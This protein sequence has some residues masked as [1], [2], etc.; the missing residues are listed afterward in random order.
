LGVRRS[1]CEAIL[2]GRVEPTPRAAHLVVTSET[3]RLE[4]RPDC[5]RD[6]VGQQIPLTQVDNRVGVVVST[7]DEDGLLEPL[8]KWQA[9]AT[10][11]EQDVGIAPGMKRF[12]RTR[13]GCSRPRRVDGCA[14]GRRLLLKVAFAQ[15]QKPKRRTCADKAE[16]V[17]RRLRRSAPLVSPGDPR[18]ILHARQARGPTRLGTGRAPV[19]LAKTLTN[20]VPSRD[21][22]LRGSIHSHGGSR[23][24]ADRP[25]PGPKFAT[26]WRPTSMRG[27]NAAHADRLK[28]T[29]RVVRC[30]KWKDI[31]GKS[32][33]AGVDR[34]SLGESFPSQR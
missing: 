5:I 1:P 11:P 26:A 22:M 14:R 16:G 9:S 3:R 18:G 25:A 8:E 24:N 31:G 33:P 2:P 34:W 29:I 27:A 15:V 21:S 13:S 32:N 28:R 6:S 23:P 20:Q 7:P 19:G 17:I 4:R 30:Q 12:R 10:R